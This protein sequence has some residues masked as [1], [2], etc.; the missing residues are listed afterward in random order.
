MSWREF[1]QEEL[2]DLRNNPYVKSATTKTVRFTAEFKERFWSEYSAGKNP[3]RI[4]KDV[5]LDPD[6]LGEPRINGIRKQH[7]Q[8]TVR[9]GEEFRDYRA[10]NITFTDLESLSPSKLLIYLQNQ[11]AYLQQ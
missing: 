5:G 3:R 8:D 1:T 2:T 9:S 10:K 7:I 6:V 11:V 4:I